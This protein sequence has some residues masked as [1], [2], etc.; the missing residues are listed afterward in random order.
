LPPPP[1]FSVR[2][3]SLTRAF[4]CQILYPIFKMPPPRVPPPPPLAGSAGAVVTPLIRIQV[5][6]VVLT[7]LEFEFRLLIYCCKHRSKSVWLRFTLQCNC[8]SGTLN[9]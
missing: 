6:I 2:R 7:P 9:Q 3:P 1:G 5:F 4:S 8:R